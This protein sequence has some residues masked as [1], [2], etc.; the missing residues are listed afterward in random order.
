MVLK[1]T[2]FQI[3]VWKYLR[4]IPKGQVV[5]GYGNN[6]SK[7]YCRIGGGNMS[8][9]RAN[10][11]DKDGNDFRSESINLHPDRFLERKHGV[12][13]N[14]IECTLKITFKSLKDLQASPPGE[15]APEKGGLRYV[16]L[17]LYPPAKYDVDAEQLNPK[18][19]EIRAF[20]GYTAPDQSALQGLNLTK[21]EIDGISAIENLNT[22][23]T[24]RLTDY[25]L[26]IANDGSVTMKTSM[27][28]VRNYKNT[29]IPTETTI[30]D[31]AS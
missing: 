13:E 7:N 25:N 15:P 11:G 9:I 19:F 14:N 21:D 18:H 24:L 8:C 29:P 6:G 1:G 22:V 4:K 3:K 5:V 26:D 27:N 31:T 23:F 30:N 20:L 12:I 28:L 10:I 17:V 16:D 2:K